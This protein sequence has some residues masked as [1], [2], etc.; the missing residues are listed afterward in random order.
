MLPLFASPRK[1][2]SS[3]QDKRTSLRYGPHY[4]NT[5]E[6]QS[7]RILPVSLQKAQFHC[8]LCWTPDALVELAVRQPKDRVWSL[9]QNQR[10]RR[11][12]PFPA[13]AQQLLTWTD[14]FPPAVSSDRHITSLGA[15]VCLCT[16]P[17]LS[18]RE[19]STQSQCSPALT[20]L[21]E[22]GQGHLFWL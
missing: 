16:S 8:E 20:L 1:C 12:G 15:R 22:A 5:G 14:R 10:S 6:Y 2:Y 17:G 3:K 9:L 13:R 4:W 11:E 7:T 18:R 19:H 21:L